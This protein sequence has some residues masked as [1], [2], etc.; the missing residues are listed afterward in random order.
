MKVRGKVI[1]C[2]LCLG[3]LS[4]MSS[5][6]VR[7]E[8]PEIKGKEGEVKERDKISVAKEYYSLGCEDLKN[9]M[10]DEAIK[11]FTK[12]IEDSSTFVSAYINLGLAYKG[13]DE[14]DE[15]ERV[16]KK[17]IVI[18]PT[19]G[20]YALGKL[21]TD[22]KRYHEAIS[23]YKEALEVDSTYVDA[24]FGIGYVEEKLGNV[25]SAIES[26]QHALRLEPENASVRYSISKAYIMVEEYEK[27]VKELTVLKEIHPEDLD[28]RRT[29][30]DALLGMK[31]YGGAKGEFEYLS[32]R[33]PLDISVRIKLG[34]ACEGLKDHKCALQAYKDAISI[35]TTDIAAYLHLIYL[36]LGLGNLSEAEQFFNTARQINPEDQQVYY[37]SGTILVK[38][39][40][41]F[42]ERKEY[43]SAIDNYEKALVAYKRVA[44]GDDSCLIDSAK[45]AIES[46]ESKLKRAKEEE[47]WHRR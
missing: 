13:K 15:M 36:Y 40:D 37:L 35:D 16:Y 10:Y 5:S 3:L 44:S 43:K 25:K 31:N 20:H 19:K 34:K 41:T 28:V 47:W 4:C 18:D 21:Y 12:A 39:G 2:I 26:Y 29:L 23:E 22:K 46:A 8:E 24:W 6:K 38:K 14:I 27:A 17:I 9:K 45:K 42:F 7:K 33:L 1:F 11:N 32:G 30:G